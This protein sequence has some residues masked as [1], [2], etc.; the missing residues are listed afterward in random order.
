MNIVTLPTKSSVTETTAGGLDLNYVATDEVDEFI[1]RTD[2]YNRGEMTADVYRAYR[3]TRGVYGQR[4]DGVHMMRVKIPGGLLAPDQARRLAELLD[5]SELGFGNITTRSNVQIHHVAPET[6]P[7]WKA[8]LNNAG[9]S[10]LDACGNSVRT[11]T[12]DPHAGLAADEVF[13]TTP[14]MQAITRFF[15]DHPR[16][17]LMPRKFKIALSTST[18][19][20]GL[21]AIHDVGLV[22]VKG[23]DDKPAFRVAIGGGLASMP[24]NAI[25]LHDAWPAEDVLTPLLAAIDMFQD[26][27]NRK[28]R[29][30]ARLKHVLRK[31]KAE[32][33]TTI[34]HTY[35][36]KVVAAP[37]AKVIADTPLWQHRPWTFAVPRETGIVGF[38]Q[39]VRSSVRPTRIQGKVFVTVRLDDGGRTTGDDLRTLAD[40]TT[41]F[42]D[43]LVVLTVHQNVL[44]RAVHT[45]DLV[46][47]YGVLNAANLARPGA[48]YASNVTSCPGTSTCNLGITSSRNL[49]NALQSVLE[50]REDSDISVKISGC[51]NSCGQHHIGTFGYYGAVKRVAGRP[52]PHYRLM[53]GGGID[54]SGATFG[55]RYGLLP[56]RRATE[57]MARVLT[58]ADANKQDGETAGDAIRRSTKSDLNPLLGDLFNLGAD[59]LTELD[60]TD[61]GLDSA[62]EVLNRKGECAA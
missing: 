12:Q 40:V 7:L 52:A 17:R 45:D 2:A 24:Q 4:Q 61:I 23:P 6:V 32:K 58:W 3:L 8:R 59:E 21:T 54:E 26:Y 46:E 50:A 47:L 5:E 43:G 39:W 57:A 34:Y 41:K 25:V 33:F 22:A 11:V 62:F 56:A 9:I 60:Y 13:D 55:Q 37:P 36:E 48:L 15:L 38:E 19:D 53:I 35:L 29:S 44:L 30:K 28:V 31:L 10:Q 27:G 49:A 42:G 1:A 20:R 16:A 18:A 51:H 14:Y